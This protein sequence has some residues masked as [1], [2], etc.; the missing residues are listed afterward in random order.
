MKKP[1]ATIELGELVEVEADE[2]QMRQLFQNLIGNAIKFAKPNVP[3]HIQINGRILPGSNLYEIQI[4]DNGI[5]FEPQYQ[6]RIFQVFQRLHGRK[7]Y[8]GTGVGLAI[9]KRI[10]ERHQGVIST[11]S[12]LNRGATFIIQLPLTQS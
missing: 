3:P 5:G 4:A 10:V 1:S 2:T 6:A 8:E 7:E 9:C 12:E 11:E